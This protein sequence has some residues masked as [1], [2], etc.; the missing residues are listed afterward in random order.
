MVHGGAG[1]WPEIELPAAKI[2]CQAAAQLGWTILNNGGSAL[3]AVEAA[4][5]A[6][7]DNPLFNAGTGSCLNQQG[8]IEMDASIMDGARH[9]AGAVAVIKHYKNPIQLARK[10]MADGRHVLLAGEGAEAFAQTQQC[11]RCDSA[12]LRVAKRVTQWQSKHG[13]VGCVAMDTQGQL[14]AGTSTGGLFDKLPGR[15]SDSALIGC[16]TYANTDGA[17]S[18]TGIGEAII[19]SVLAKTTVD[20][21]RHHVSASAAV[22]QIIAQ[23]TT[24]TRRQAGVIVID[25]KGSIAFAHNCQAM[26]V[27]FV[28]RTGNIQ[29]AH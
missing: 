1:A 18:C 27:A 29:V 21:L 11:S 17:V 10:V 7:E 5:V 14:A 26:P 24:D 13:T 23:F 19:R 16:G 15:I 28:D 22:Q 4:I 3:D 12:S 8:E 2:G 20:A 9:A 25:N 6:L